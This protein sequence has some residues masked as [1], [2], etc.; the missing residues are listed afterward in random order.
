[1]R[2]HAT[3]AQRNR[4]IF[5]FRNQKNRSKR[6]GTAIHLNSQNFIHVNRVT[7]NEIICY[8][9]SQEQFIRKSG[10]WG[11]FVCLFFAIHHHLIFRL[12][13]VCLPYYDTLVSKPSILPE[14]P[15]TWQSRWHL[16]KQSRKEKKFCISSPKGQPTTALHTSTS[17]KKQDLIE[18][19]TQLKN[20]QVVLLWWV[21]LGTTEWKHACWYF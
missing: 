15:P 4:D 18:E 5:Q 11:L 8:F 7:C 16:L 17:D 19:R 2:V 20:T 12:K 14:E 13:Y 6:K 21:I 9:S 1:M 3:A 10:G